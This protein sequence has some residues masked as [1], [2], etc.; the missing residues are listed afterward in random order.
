MTLVDLETS[1]LAEIRKTLGAVYVEALDEGW[2]VRDYVTAGVDLPAILIGTH[3]SIDYNG[4]LSGGAEVTQ[5]ATAIVSLGDEE[6][7]QRTI[8]LVVSPRLVAP[9]LS[10]VIPGVWKGAAQVRAGKPYT[11]TVG[12]TK[13]L[14][15]DITHRIIA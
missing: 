11:L 6:T 7:A 1:W 10:R 15:V 2:H 8:D 4:T 12:D 5:I 3:E 14:A 9:S 13:A